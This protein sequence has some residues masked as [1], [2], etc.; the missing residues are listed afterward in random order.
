MPVSRIRLGL[1][2]ATVGL[3]A[4]LGTAGAGAT[5]RAARPA[6]GHTNNAECIVPGT[7]RTIDQLYRPNLRAAIAYARTRAGDIAFAVRSDESFHGYRADHVEWSAS[8]VKS[9][10]LVAY[11]NEPWVADRQINTSD[12]S[13]LWP[14]I[15]Q[16]DNSAADSVYQIVGPGALYALAA[17]VGMRSFSTQSIWGE[18]HVTARGLTKF[19]LHIDSYVV[20]R[21]AGYV[22]AAL[23]HI[24]PS[25]RW[26]IGEVAPK[27]W[28]LYFK[29]GWGYGTGL[30]DSQVALLRRGCA[31][32]SMAVLT[33]HDG[34][35][36]YGKQTLHDLFARL[37]RGFP[38]FGSDVPSS[39]RGHAWPLRMRL[40]D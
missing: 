2:T 24:I 10:L 20:R 16:S 9:M 29:G 3:G 37:L 15:T 34:S 26:G 5:A 13:L 27:G 32:V 40:D 17:R 1:A 4:L 39:A 19:F 11:L 18:T 14:M 36:P 21:H 22:M 12:N 7:R 25:E 8:M 38:R 23:N 6:R 35:H 30:I 28:K 33:M 31:R